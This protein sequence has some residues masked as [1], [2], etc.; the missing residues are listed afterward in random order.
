MSKKKKDEELYTESGVEYSQPNYIRSG[1]YDIDTNRNYR[2][3]GREYADQ[4]NYGRAALMERMRNAK[5]DAGYGNEYDKSYAYN[6]QPKYLGKADEL[7]G[8]LENYGDFSWDIN[9][10]GDYRALANVYSANARKASN[11]ALAQMAA[12]NGGR[13]SSNA[14]IAASQ[15]YQ[16][17]MSGLEAEIPQLRQAAYNM[18]RDNKNDLRT[19]MYDTEAAEDTNYSRW[20]DDYNRRYENTWDLI[21]HDMEKQ[22]LAETVANG[23]AQ[24][25]SLAFTD[26]LAASEAAGY[27]TA[28]LEAMTGIPQGTPMSEFRKTIEDMRFNIGNSVGQFPGW[29]LGSYGYGDQNMPTIDRINSDRNYEVAKEANAIDRANGKITGGGGSGGSNGSGGSG[30]YGDY[31]TGDDYSDDT[32]NDAYVEELKTRIANGATFPEI[33]EEVTANYPESEGMEIFKKLG[34]K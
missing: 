7:R 22:R 17:K 8:Q 32:S 10:D 5:I 14:I 28:D 20:T 30:D 31:G 27:A 18:Y 34:F 15:A 23:Q 13:L 12:A 19:L 33:W 25:N 26:A 21:N 9:T 4:G 11:N 29:W 24:R 1:G 6:Y 3:A 16:D 2:Q